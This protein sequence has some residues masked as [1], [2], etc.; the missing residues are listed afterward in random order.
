MGA[1][2]AADGARTS[3]DRPAGGFSPL[4]FVGVAIAS[5]GGPLALINFLPATAGDEGLAS[6]G[7]VVLLALLVFAAPLAI[8]LV[9]SRRIVSPGGLTAFVDAAAGRRMAVVHGWIWAIAYFLYLP[10]T[11]TFV[12]YDVLAPV[13]PGIVPYRWVLELV[14]PVAIV[15][16]VLAPLRLALVSLLVVGVAQLVLLLALGGVAMAHLPARF[17][18]E[19]SVDPTGRAVAGTALLFVCASLPLYLGAEA[20][21]GSRTVR[22]GLTIAV[23]VVGLCFFVAALGFSQ[24]PDALLRAPVPAEAVAHYYGS[25]NFGVAVGLGIAA[26]TLALIVAEYLALGRLLHWLYDIPLRRVLVWI[27]VPFVA[28]DVLSLI[29]P[30]QFYDKLL[31][32]SL[33]ALFI[34]QLVVFLVFPL[35]RKGVRW[36]PLVAVASGLMAWGFYQLVAGSAS[37]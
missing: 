27:A 28:A 19:P 8:W 11:V 33:G 6:A 5:I 25:R 21:G 36:W 26:G 16:L 3:R 20:R 2:S 17:S 12:V 1:E 10:Y 24:V 13:F 18:S 15:V 22:R 23:A 35:Y 32:P 14:L 29:N 34:S 30:E 7:L 37:T 4:L 9:Y 31:E